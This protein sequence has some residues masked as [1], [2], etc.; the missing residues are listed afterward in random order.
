VIWGR[1]PAYTNIH[2][3]PIIQEAR[4]RGARV[5]LV[6]PIR[7]KTA[8][9]ADLVVQ[10]RPGTDGALA[11]A[12]ALL[13]L[14]APALEI[15]N[16]GLPHP[17]FCRDS[18]ILPVRVEGVP[19]GLLES[20]EYESTALKL[21]PGDTAVFYSDGI[22]EA[23]N[24]DQEEF[25]RS[26]LRDV[27][28]AHCAGTAVHL[29]ERIFEAAENWAAG[30]PASDDR[31]VVVLKMGEGAGSDACSCPSCARRATPP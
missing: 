25:G 18:E 20:V 23:L 13:D 16:A 2:L 22:T 1:N 31:T 3:I 24:R 12:V 7:T 19:L 30:R 26:R 11:L 10:P 9:F 6:D 28:Q 21:R 4:R 14:E 8:S 17:I 27:I 15:A 29:V 5:A